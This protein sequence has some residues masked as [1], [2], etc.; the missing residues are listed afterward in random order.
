MEQYR[1]NAPLRQSFDAL[2]NATFG[3]NFE[4]WYQ[5]GL[6]IQKILSP[7]K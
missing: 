1:D 4:H 2:A 3:L 5:M 6:F 7:N